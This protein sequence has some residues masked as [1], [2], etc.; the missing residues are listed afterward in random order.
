MTLSTMNVH[1]YLL[2][3][4]VYCINKF[5]AFKMNIYKLCNLGATSQKFIVLKLVKSCE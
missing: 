2:S 1:G 4:V 5:H 3:T